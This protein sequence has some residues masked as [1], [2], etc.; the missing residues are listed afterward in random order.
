MKLLTKIEIIAVISLFAIVV[1]GL[2]VIADLKEDGL[3]CI[4]NP[5]KFGVNKLSKAVDSQVQCS[6]YV[7]RPGTLPIFIDSSP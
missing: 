5:L 3:Q 4:D 1:W 6:C 7:G 2:F